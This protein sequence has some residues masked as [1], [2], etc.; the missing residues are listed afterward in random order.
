MQNLIQRLYTQN[1]GIRGILE[2][3]EPVH[4]CTRRI[5]Q[6]PVVFTN[7]EKSDIFKTEYIF[8]TLLKI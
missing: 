6:N 4:N 3:A 5:I 8:Q 1:L 7:I 2:Y